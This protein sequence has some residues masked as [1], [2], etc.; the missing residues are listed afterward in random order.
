VLELPK[1]GGIS[2]LKTL[3]KI[4][5]TKIHAKWILT[6]KIKLKYFKIVVSSKRCF[7]ILSSSQGSWKSNKNCSADLNG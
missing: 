7:F 2:N 1:E 3:D 4:D 5:F 6:L